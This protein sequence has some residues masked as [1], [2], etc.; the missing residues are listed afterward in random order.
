MALED[1]KYWSIT[2]DPDTRSI[3]LDW[4]DATSAMTADD[5]K[6]A[7]EHLAEHIRE[8][9]VT[10]T[11]INLRSFHFAPTPELD[12]WRREEIVPAY[13]SGGLKRFAY[14]LPEGADYRPG[15]G[16]EGDEFITDWFEDRDDA[17]A[18]L[19]QA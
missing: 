9:S 2:H 8:Q 12:A 15:G 17:R 7:L 13:N 1:T 3:E 11:L 6:E 16:G 5:F 4:K 18:W 10:G 19:Q 14:L